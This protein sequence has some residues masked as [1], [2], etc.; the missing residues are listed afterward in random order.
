MLGGYRVYV[1]QTRRKMLAIDRFVRLEAG[2]QVLRKAQMSDST[3]ISKNWPQGK[4]GSTLYLRNRLNYRSM[5]YPTAV[6]MRTPR[7]QETSTR[8]RAS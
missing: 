2:P 4:K 3:T 8:T 7:M 6:P 5:V 1:N